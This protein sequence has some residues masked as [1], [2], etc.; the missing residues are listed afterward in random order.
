M[1]DYEMKKGLLYVLQGWSDTTQPKKKKK[2]KTKQNNK[3]SPFEIN[4]PTSF[5]KKRNFRS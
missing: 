1:T 3:K 2:K 4:L 5:Y